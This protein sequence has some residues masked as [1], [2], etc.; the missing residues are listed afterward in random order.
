MMT[1]WKFCVWSHLF[2]ALV[3]GNILEAIHESQ[4][5][6]LESF[7]NATGYYIQG[8]NYCEH[9]GLIC[10]SEGFILSI[11]LRES[12]LVGTIPKEIHSLVRLRALRLNDNA[13]FGELPTSLLGMNSLRYLNLGHNLFEG[14]FPDFTGLMALRRLILD[15]NSFS[16]TI[17]SEICQLT[18]LEALELSA[19]TKLYGTLPS[20]LGNLTSLNV[21]RITDIGLTGTIPPDLC[22]GREMNGFDPNPFGC[23]AI[24]CDAGFHHRGAGRQTDKSAPCTPCNVPSNALS[25]STCQWIS[26]DGTSN[27]HDNSDVEKG[28][29]NGLY[30]E[31]AWP[32]ASPTYYE[33]PTEPPSSVSYP[34]ESPQLEMQS[35]IMPTLGTTIQ[36]LPPSM[37]PTELTASKY[38]SYQPSE[39]PST[40]SSPAPSALSTSTPTSGI[41]LDA[42][43]A[44]ENP[45]TGGLVG[46]SATA[47]ACV[48]I[49]LLF[50]LSRQG[51]RQGQPKYFIR[52]ENED[53][54]ERFLVQNLRET[55][56]P[57]HV[58]RG[59][60][61]PG[62]PTLRSPSD[63]LSTI[64]EEDSTAASRSD[65]LE[66]M[67]K[68]SSTLEPTSP[69]NLRETRT[70]KKVRFAFPPALETYEIPSK[71]PTHDVEAAIV[72]ESTADTFGNVDRWATWIMNPVFDCSRAVKP[73]LDDERS[74]HSLDAAST[75]SETPMLSQT[76]SD[77]S[78]STVVSMRVLGIQERK[79]DHGGP[80]TLMETSRPSSG[81]STNHHSEDKKK[82]KDAPRK[83]A[84]FVWRRKGMAEI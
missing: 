27:G 73:P 28:G 51:S 46:G 62:L 69:P 32:S 55:M 59:I 2:A 70:T 82:K 26:E 45:S 50:I 54:P 48:L 7:Y 83:D 6:A 1:F 19:C 18:N 5:L 8:S 60:E 53:E 75:N 76:P 74:W 40:T 21:L 37:E 22:D 72:R 24:G 35:S 15:R 63:S 33:Q 64:E 80:V 11:D 23:S 13:L 68:R 4:W 25:S 47:G 77:T 65:S 79:N 10:D 78:S 17:P 81:A 58:R 31:S 84:R 14:T 67:F 44:R 36:S 12:S 20:C 71:D 43:E 49:F 52:A 9:P 30:E 42:S 57:Q 61:A 3:H 16:G 41:F 39:S 66:S 38:P 56:T 29:R 34:T